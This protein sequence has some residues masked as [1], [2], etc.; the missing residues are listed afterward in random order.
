MAREIDSYYRK[1]EEKYRVNTD[2]LDLFQKDINPRMR[3]ILIDWLVEVGE[4]YKLVP[5]TLHTSVNLVDRCLSK[6]K[7]PRGQLQLLGCACMM[8]A[9]KY[10]EVFGP[11][12]EEFV[13]ISDHTYTAEQML[14]MEAK[15]LEALDFRISC[16]T[17]YHFLQRFISAGCKTD[18]QQ[19]LAHVMHFIKTICLIVFFN[20]RDTNF[21]LYAL[22]VSHRI[23]NY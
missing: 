17:V 20:H 9:V 7:V 2:Y 8:I 5:Q 10:E 14:E 4:E 3:G 23:G 6:M 12:V 1:H 16:T 13:Y 22:I 21:Y 19:H 15:V 18:V 11:S